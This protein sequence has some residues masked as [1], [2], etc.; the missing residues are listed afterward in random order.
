M[1]ASEINI[2][3]V[4]WKALEYN[5]KEH[6]VD[7]YWAVGLVTLVVCGIAIWTK[8]YVF[9]IF[10]LIAGATLLLVNIRHPEQVDYSIE[11]SGLTMGKDKY[12]W[13]RIKGFDI[14]KGE[15]ISKLLIETNK[16]FL[17]VYTIPI[18]NDLVPEVKESLQKI[19]PLIELNESQSLIFMEKLGF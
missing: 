16:H 18:P 19:I 14:K 6:S 2:N 11:S 4:E 9:G 10:I 1:H 3:K 7:W 12:E 15:D 17:P 13:A 8:N 5:H